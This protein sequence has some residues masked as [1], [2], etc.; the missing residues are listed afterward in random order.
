MKY[1]VTLILL[2]LFF[3][4]KEKPK[5]V[6]SDVTKIP[7]KHVST[8]ENEYPEALDKVFDAHGGLQNWRGKRTL[9]FE[10]P[11]PDAREWHTVDLYSRKDKIALP[12]A[13]LGYDG[14]N[15]WLLDEAKTYKGNAALYHNLMFYFYTMP[16]VFAD[17]N[18]N[19]KKAEDLVFEGKSYPGVHMSYNDGVG[20]SSKDE[21]YLHYDPETYQMAWL[22]YTFTYGSDE[23]SDDVRWIRYEDWMRVS[24][25]VL[26]KSITW[27]AYEGRMIKA[28][29]RTVSFENVT[30][31][32]KAKPD[33]FYKKPEK[34]GIVKGKG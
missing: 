17:K 33:G 28:P 11:K 27:Y 8:E 32:E 3:S 20:A 1:Q 10:I 23:P 5:E 26:P 7:E 6:Q 12:D 2:V 14:E 16:Y 13:T 15:V 21:Y 24:D 22:G 4:C 29:K 19:Y 25:M 34:A 30:V 9:E 18:I 31:S